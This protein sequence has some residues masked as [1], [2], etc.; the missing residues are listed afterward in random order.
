MTLRELRLWHW[1]ECLRQRRA[2]R[3]AGSLRWRVRH[4]TQA[5]MHLSA[6][7]LLNEHFDTVN[8]DTAENDDVRR[9]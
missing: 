1:Q 7:Q 9:S 3:A 8:G 2:E 4:C 6:V 5:D